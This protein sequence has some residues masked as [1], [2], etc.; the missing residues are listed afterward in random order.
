MSLISPLQRYPDQSTREFL[1]DVTIL[2]LGAQVTT[3]ITFFL[4][5]NIRIARQ[6]AWDQTVASRGKGA[7]FWQPYVEEWEVPPAVHEGFSARLG[8]VMEIW[9]IGVV[10]KKGPCT[11]ILICYHRDA[12]LLR[13]SASSSIVPISLPGYICSCRHQSFGHRTAPA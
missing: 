1:S 8:N 5:R 4:S 11:Y 13:S 3:V 12:E 9:I 2:L 7:D 10:V 6:R